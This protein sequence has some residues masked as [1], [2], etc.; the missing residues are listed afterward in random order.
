MKPPKLPKSRR[1]LAL[2]GGGSSRTS[3]LFLTALAIL[4]L[5]GFL[6]V[7]FVAMTE[8]AEVDENAYLAS[9]DHLPKIT[10]SPSARIDFNILSPVKDSAQTDRLVREPEP[11]TH[12]L[13]EAR[14]LTP[15]DLEALGLRD[16]NAIEILEDPALHRGEPFMVKGI[17]ESIDVVQGRVWQEVRGT[18]RDDTGQLY[19]FTVLRDPDVEV[20]QFVILRGFFFKLFTTES[21]PGEFADNTIYLVGNRLILSF[22]RMEPVTD[23]SQIP[24]DKARDFD[25]TDMVELQ[26]DL[27]YQVLSYARALD[28]ETKEE[29]EATEVRWIDLRKQPEVYRGQPVR[30]LARH[31]PGLDWE[32]RMGPG[33]EN[34][35]N[36]DVF[37]NGILA[38]A[39]NRLVRWIGLE[40]FPVAEVPSKLSYLTGIFVKNLAWENGRG[41]IL[42]GPLIVP[43]RFDAFVYPKNEAIIQIGYAISA[44]VMVLIVAFFVG[45]FWDSRRSAKYR[46]EFLQRKK[47]SLSR[48]LEARESN[49]AGDETQDS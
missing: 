44:T 30:I 43:L 22:M 31:V 34:P 25:I 36:V 38:L 33:G 9:E 26:E 1:P 35:L 15:G 8:K 7:R 49:S 23:L 10:R 39:N 4:F 45:V 12:L 21:A 14:K 16:M 27:L 3:L 11:Y 24:F 29:I 42:N 20:G 40:P 47:R 46:Q 2:G 28:D 32:A 13:T 37:H 5:G 19:S 18:V 48:A 41:E 6:Y 17:L